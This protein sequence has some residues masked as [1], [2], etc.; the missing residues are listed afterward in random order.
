MKLSEFPAGTVIDVQGLGRFERTET[1][2]LGMSGPQDR[3]IEDTV[4]KLDEMNQ[5]KII[6]VPW[7]IVAQL[8][9]MLQE[10]YG[11]VDAEGEDITFNRVLADALS[12]NADFKKREAAEAQNAS[13]V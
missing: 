4:N 5:V 13:S 11:D 8:V 2:W 7:G 12:L 10:E 6:S 1:E 3:L 9:M